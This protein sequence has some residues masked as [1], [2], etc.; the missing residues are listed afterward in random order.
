MKSPRMAFRPAS[1]ACALV[2]L[3]AWLIPH[4]ATAQNVTTHYNPA[5]RTDMYGN[6]RPAADERRLVGLF[7][8]KIQREALR[9]YQYAGRRANRRGGLIQFAFRSDRARWSSLRGRAPVPSVSPG[10]ISPAMQQA[11][12]RYGGFGRRAGQRQAGDIAMVLGRRTALIQATSLNAPV[13]RAMWELGSTSGLLT[14]MVSTPLG[15]TEVVEPSQDASTLDQAL[16][17]GVLRSYL[18]S[19]ADGWTWFAE[20]NYRR[21][22]RAFETAALLEPADFESRIAEMFCYLSL[23]A[24]RTSAR[25]LEQL[26]RRD[27]N[28]FL[29]DIDIANR[30]G[31]VER[32]REVRLRTRLFAQAN[33]GVASAEALHIFTLWHFGERDEAVGAAAGSSRDLTGS[34]YADWPA[35]ISAAEAAVNTVDEQP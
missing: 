3:L 27:P 19:R 25:L 7:Q 9:G 31:A 20:G 17:H 35:K 34:V 32:S 18:R 33:A 10:A 15:Q 21:A 26:A 23:G 22:A 1:S 16:R 5:S 2:F 24:M 30:Y 29:H 13:R 14:P 6:A 12:L 28:P 4:E 11:F 8:N